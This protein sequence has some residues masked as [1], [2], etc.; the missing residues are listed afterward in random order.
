MSL[1]IKN[2]KPAKRYA[3]AL[4]ES[5]KD[6]LDTVIEDLE[7]VNEI[8]FKNKDFKMFFTHP[9]VS[10]SDKKDTLKATLEGKIN[11]ISFNFLNTLL[12][13]GRF[14]LFETAFELLKN[15]ADI[16]KNKQKVEIISAVCLDDEIK[17][18]LKKTLDNKL[19]KDAILNYSED[20]GIL[21]GLIV[22]FEDKVIDLSLKTK[23]EVL[24][25]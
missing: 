23:F 6:N 13:E 20:I 9:I 1:D 12:T 14:P 15:Q 19:K 24:R 3:L 10:L 18:R 8:I 17:D 21:G 16:L 25:K 22:K 4:F 5:A 7:A 2:L 11:E